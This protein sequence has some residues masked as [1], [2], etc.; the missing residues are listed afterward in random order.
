MNDCI[1]NIVSYWR[2]VEILY[3]N[4]EMC[5][6]C[7]EYSHLNKKTPKRRLGICCAGMDILLSEEN[8]LL[9]LFKKK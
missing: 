7:G 3:Q 2:N 1:K 8:Y 6:I 9:L 5:I 4:D